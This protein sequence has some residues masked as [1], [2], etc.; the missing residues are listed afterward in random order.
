MTAAGCVVC[1]KGTDAVQ[2]AQMIAGLQRVNMDMSLF[3][4]WAVFFPVDCR[5][6]W[7]RLTNEKLLC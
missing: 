2:A 5:I 1:G 3:L 7:K 4:Y 6:P